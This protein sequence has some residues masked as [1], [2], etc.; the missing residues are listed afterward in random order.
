MQPR[1]RAVKHQTHGLLRVPARGVAGRVGDP[2]LDTL[3]LIQSNTSLWK[4]S[5]VIFILM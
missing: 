1:P 3:T 5:M 2:A 4:L